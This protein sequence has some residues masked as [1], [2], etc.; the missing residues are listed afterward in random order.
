MEF[1]KQNMDVTTS[2]DPKTL[3]ELQD[4]AEFNKN[5]E[6]AFTPTYNYSY[7]CMNLRPEKGHKKLFTDKTVRRAIAHLVPFDDIK[8]VI[9]KGKNKRVVGPVSPSKAEYNS[10]LEL[11]PYDIAKAKQL[12]ESAGWKDTDGDNILDKMIDGEKVKF[13]F[14]LGYM[15]TTNTWADLAKLLAE[16]F[17]KA[18]IKANLNPLQYA[19]QTE[20]AHNHDFDMFVGSWGG[21]SLP[22]DFT[23]LWHTD[24]WK[25][26]GSNYSG[27][28]NAQSDALSDSIKYELDPAKRLPMVKRMQ[29]MIY[30]EQ[31]YVF[32]FASTRR[33]AIHKRFDNRAMYAER[34][35]VL[36]NQLKLNSAT[37]KDAA[38]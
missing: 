35:G 24:S 21:I 27:F 31:P 6:S 19:V 3:L 30:D 33:V 16:S 18:G 26:K 15:A 25:T 38:E 1:K 32:L 14:K 34:P 37:V 2:L 8:K 28:G 29:Q 23:Q 5:Y 10:D 9:Y 12:F 36:L 4:D 7:I 13:E 11:I 17:E 22:E 20:K